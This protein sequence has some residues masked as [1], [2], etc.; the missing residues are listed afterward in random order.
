MGPVWAIPDMITTGKLKQFAYQDE[1]R[2]AY[3]K[4]EAFKFQNCTYQLSNPRARPAPNPEEHH[5]ETLQLGDLCD[6]CRIRVF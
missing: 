1:Y 4:T 2:F 5:D 3:T 6:I